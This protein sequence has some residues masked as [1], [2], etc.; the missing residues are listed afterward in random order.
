MI[1]ALGI[2]SG[3]PIPRPDDMATYGDH[4]PDLRYATGI[5]RLALIGQVNR[6][7]HQLAVTVAHDG[8]S[9]SDL[10]LKAH[11]TPVYH[12]SN[13]GGP[14]AERDKTPATG[15]LAPSVV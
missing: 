6:H 11:G 7:L 13:H 5:V 10:V 1:I 4:S 9:F 8:L 15:P 2:D 12:A 14:P 3:V